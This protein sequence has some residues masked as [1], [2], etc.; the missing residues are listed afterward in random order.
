M[1]VRFGWSNDVDVKLDG[2]P[3]IKTDPQGWSWVAPLGGAQSAWV[4]LVE[5]K[6]NETLKTRSGTD[7]SWRIYR[8]CVGLGYFLLGDAA[9]ILDPLSSHGVLR[10]LM[11]GIFCG[12]LIFAH[13]ARRLSEA[14]II[15]HYA[16]WLT[17]QFDLDVAALS[18]LYRRHPSKELANIFCALPY[19]GSHNHTGRAFRLKPKML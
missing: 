7:V 2:Q 5:A 17:Q 11:S 10:A 12:H 1:I 4:S 15:R 13:K 6:P 8:D 14:D 3:R 19:D 16:L 9:A 18:A